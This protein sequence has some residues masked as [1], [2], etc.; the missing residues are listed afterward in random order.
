MSDKIKELAWG[1]LLD[2]DVNGV[3]NFE[4]IK[5]ICHQN[6]W[7][8]ISYNEGRG[9]IKQFKLEKTCS[10][11]S[12]ICHFYDNQ[13][14]IL[15][16]DTIETDNIIFS[17]AKQIGC[18]ILG[19]DNENVIGKIITDNKKDT[20]QFA[21]ELLLPSNVVKNACIYKEIMNS[22]GLKSQEIQDYFFENR[23]CDTS[24]IKNNQEILNKYR[25]IASYIH[26]ELTEYNNQ[27]QERLLEKFN[28]TI[29]KRN[30]EKAIKKAIKIVLPITMLL[31]IVFTY[32]FIFDGTKKANT[33]TASNSVQSQNTNVLQSVST[34]TDNKENET[35]KNEPGSEQTSVPISSPGT[36]KEA[37]L[38][39]S[40][41]LQDIT[42]YVTKTGKKYH[43]ADCSS[44]KNRSTKIDISLE[45]AIRI[46]YEPCL[47]C[48]PDENIK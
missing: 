37:N 44:I 33:K 17:I 16:D 12:A 31:V 1:L 29:K 20:F 47:I 14:T 4:G 39:E 26:E 48:R 28:P 35:P 7:N 41:Q 46:G 8:V 24:D 25:S 43:L 11:N 27:L 2:S 5:K 32:I 36:E 23:Y 34:D 22:L 30:K 3:L 9:Y 15:Y 38:E 13:Y 40:N 18:I 45:D 21:C 42:V 19:S 6:N 10:Q